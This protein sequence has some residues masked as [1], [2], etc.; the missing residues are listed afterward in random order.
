MSAT[1]KEEQ[2]SALLKEEQTSATARE[3]PT[4]DTAKQATLKQNIKTFTTCLWDNDSEM[5]FSK[6]LQL[7]DD[8]MDCSE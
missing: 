5:D 1:E 2:T 8:D 4:S 7:N 6:P 3:E